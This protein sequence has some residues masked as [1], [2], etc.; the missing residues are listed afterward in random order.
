MPKNKFISWFGPQVGKKEQILLS[1]V[2]KSGYINDGWATRELENK[3]AER[4]GVKYC[5]GVT[6]GTCALTL[7]LLGLGVGP[8]DEVLVPD[9]TFIASANAVRLAGASVRLVDV[10]PHRLTID[11]DQIKKSVGPK[12]KA[13]I[14]VDVNGRGCY[15]DVLEPWAKKKGIYLVTDSC[16][17]LGSKYK[18]KALGSFGDA[19]CFSFSANKTVSTGQGGAITTNNKSLYEKLLQLK[20]Q[21]RIAQGTGGNDLHPHLGYNFKL[22]NLQSAVGLAQWEKLEKRLEQARKRDQWY[23][24]FLHGVPGIKFFPWDEKGG[25]VFQWTDILISNRDRVAAALT[26]SEIGFRNSWYPLHTQRPY[27]GQK[28]SFPVSLEFSLEMMWLPSTFDLKKDTVQTVSN[29]IR[30]SIS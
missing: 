21:G 25:E 27:M 30:K 5:V 20:D 12:T 10:E 24:E 17:G 1:R 3:L 29:V 6:S 4:I 2:I 18:N 7:S 26:A 23:R 16:E 9:M 22:T 15:Y 19:G 11:P 13:I 14:A 8:G 28:G